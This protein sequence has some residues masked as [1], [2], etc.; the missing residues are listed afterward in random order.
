[1]ICQ[2]IGCKEKAYKIVCIPFFR[3]SDTKITEILVC[4]KHD[5][6]KDRL[7]RVKT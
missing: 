3:L 2:I 5:I 6:E 4:Q 1:M 7:E